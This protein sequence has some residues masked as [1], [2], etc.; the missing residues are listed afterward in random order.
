MVLFEWVE[1]AYCRMHHSCILDIDEWGFIFTKTT[2][3]ER[4]DEDQRSLKE[5]KQDEINRLKNEIKQEQ[6]DFDTWSR[7]DV[8]SSKENEELKQKWIKDN[9]FK[10]LDENL[11][12]QYNIKRINTLEDE[13]KS[14]EKYEENEQKKAWEKTRNQ[15]FFRTGG[16]SGKKKNKRNIKTKKNKKKS[17]RR[18]F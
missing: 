17:R 10:N 11:V 13:I 15:G 18:R 1:H 7:N 5:K 3:R 14:I 9:L 6:F 2:F 12:S 4:E 8:N 16:K